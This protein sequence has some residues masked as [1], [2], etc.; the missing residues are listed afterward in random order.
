MA[1]VGEVA[2]GAAFDVS[3]AGA[4]AIADAVAAGVGAD[5]GAVAVLKAGTGLTVGKA[6]SAKL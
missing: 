6:G 3:F 2:A 1:T 4:G 5:A